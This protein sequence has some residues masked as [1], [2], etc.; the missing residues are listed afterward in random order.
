MRW[1]IH[2]RTVELKSHFSHF[3]FFLIKNMLQRNNQ[4]VDTP[5]FKDLCV[6]KFYQKKVFALNIFSS[7]YPKMIYLA[8]EIEIGIEI[9]SASGRR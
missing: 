9:V 3:F 8:L 2:N 1:Y 7:N 5:K 6:G 4:N